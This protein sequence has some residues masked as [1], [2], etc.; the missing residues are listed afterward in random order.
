[1][2]VRQALR[3]DAVLRASGYKAQSTLYLKIS[4]LKFP[5]G[6]KL[7]PGGQTRIW[8]EDEIEL[9][10]KG[11]WRPTPEATEAWEKKQAAKAASMEAA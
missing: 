6:H 5:P 4:E 11:E 1:M 3:I 10:Q 8:W 9:W 2:A 7:D